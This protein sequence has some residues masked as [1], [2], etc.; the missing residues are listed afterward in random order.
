MSDSKR[1]DQLEAKHEDNQQ[2]R[3]EG[4]VRWVEYITEQPV[5]VWGPQQNAVV[6][7]QLESA[8]QA[9]LG[10]DHERRVRQFADAVLAETADRES[11]PDSDADS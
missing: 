3:L 7:A 1:F 11:E 8:Q 9:E 4:I 5:D 2:Q 6:N 10:V